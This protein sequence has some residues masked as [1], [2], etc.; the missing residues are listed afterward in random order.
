MSSLS[1]ICCMVLGEIKVHI[2][3]SAANDLSTALRTANISLSA[4]FAL[5]K[6]TRKGDI[7]AAGQIIN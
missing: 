2:S 5:L 3:P 1:K 4:R 6:F 7:G